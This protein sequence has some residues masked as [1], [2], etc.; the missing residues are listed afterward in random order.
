MRSYL[1]PICCLIIYSTI[2]SLD[3]L[4]HWPPTEKE[5]TLMLMSIL[6]IFITVNYALATKYYHFN[7]YQ[8]YKHLMIAPLVPR[9]CF[10]KELTFYLK[11]IENSIFYLTTYLFF[12][13]FLGLNKIFIVTVSFIFYFVFFSYAL[14]LIR[15]ICG[16]SIKGRSTF[17]T[18]CLLINAIVMY[19][20][21]LISKGTSNIVAI[22]FVE[23]NPL[24][25]IFFQSILS[26][27]SEWII[28]I[29]YMFF[30]I[31]I[32]LLTRNLSWRKQLETI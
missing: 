9:Q 24:N 17:Y 4:F 31:I 15:F 23:Y 30:L 13:Y 16:H 12:L 7:I 14:I 25:T 26:G 29:P 8:N 11:S 18:I 19:Q 1:F 22:I 32:Y 6:T 2:I 5:D 10:I 21:L 3:F 28:Y 20:I 27:T